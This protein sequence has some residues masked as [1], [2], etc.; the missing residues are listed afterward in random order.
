MRKS[1]SHSL[2]HARVSESSHCLCDV[3][4]ASSCFP[5][6]F[7]VGPFLEIP[8]SGLRT[9]NWI[10]REFLLWVE[11]WLVGMLLLL[12]FSVVVVVLVVFLVR[13]FVVVEFSVATFV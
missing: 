12:L 10:G 6:T 8:D 13:L 5:P 11:V 4:S 2:G 3:G 1:R 7:C 9:L